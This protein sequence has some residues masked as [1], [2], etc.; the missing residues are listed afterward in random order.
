MHGP[1]VARRQGRR[2]GPPTGTP[3]GCHN[4]VCLGHNGIGWVRDPIAPQTSEL[5]VL[6]IEAVLTR[7][8]RQ[9]PER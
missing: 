4:D 2:P 8:G 3:A 6:C 9:R 7:V 5:S 1:G